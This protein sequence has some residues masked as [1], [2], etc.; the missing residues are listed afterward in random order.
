M[1][2]N[3]R[4]VVAVSGDGAAQYG[5]HTLY[6][7]ARHHLPVTFLTMVNGEYGILRIFGEHLGIEDTPG[8]DVGGLDYEALALGYGVSTTRTSTIDKLTA[9]LDDAINRPTGPRVV[10]ADI[11]LGVN[12]KD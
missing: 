3:S 7:A 12:L 11:T 2:G 8:L 10:L 1:I 5:I 9:A 4:P 6:T